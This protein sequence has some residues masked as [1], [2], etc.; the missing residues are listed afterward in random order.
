MH[1]LLALQRE[2]YLTQGAVS[3]ETRVDR[4]DRALRLVHGH[5]DRIIAALNDDFGCRSPHQSQMSD[6]YATMEALKHAKKH[7]GRWMA[8]EKRKIAFP[9]N[10][11]GARGHV[12]YQPK[13]VVGIL[14][15]WN[16]AVNTVFGPLA[17]V[18]AAGNRAMLKFS[19]VAPATAALMES[20]V[21]STFDPSEVGCVTGGPEVGAAFSALP[22]DHL[23]FT[24][25]AAIGK[26]VMRAAAE[27]LTPVTLELG[28]KSPA[29]VAPDYDLAEA[30]ARIMTGKS[31]N[32]GQ[33]CL[34]PDY[35]FVPAAQ[36]E[37]FAQHAAEFTAGMYPTILANRDFTSIVDARHLARLQR[38]LDEART[39]GVDVRAINPA[40]E[41]L[42]TQKGTH[43]LPFTL[44][45]DP[46]E[47]L[48]LMREELFGPILILKPYDALRDCTRYVA[49]HPRPLGLY[50][51]THD[52]RVVQ[53]VLA[54]TISGGV[55]VNDVMVHASAEDLPFGGTG[56]SGMGHYHGQDGF[57]AFSHARP[58]YRQTKLP[59]QRLGGM[60]PPFGERAEKQL[61]K[62]T[63]L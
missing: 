5:Q 53:D 14:G 28:G 31:L 2:A 56:P 12:H 36:L 17:G 49:T 34:A 9:L 13:G 18:L 58:V 6:I 15:T 4:L 26:Q 62:M 39:A 59:L 35:V 30:A 24:G 22:L 44:V 42:S 48:A 38:Y 46:P 51:F 25:S 10:L 37:A 63:S 29:V 45:V 3:L 16:F 1:D 57:K 32:V 50:V 21:A 60:L 40:G 27:H 61:K 47:E 43:K 8:P 52:E 7:V 20:L 54:H 23:V 11:F 19:E 55:V 41:D 33:A